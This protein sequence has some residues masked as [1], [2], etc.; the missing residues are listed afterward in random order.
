[1]KNCWLLLYFPCLFALVGKT[2]E[3]EVSCCPAGG[4]CGAVSQVAGRALTYC[5]HYWRL[6]MDFHKFSGRATLAEA[7]RG[8]EVFKKITVYPTNREIPCPSAAKSN[9]L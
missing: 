9:L 6:D 4:E 7:E 1:M 2:L 8:N 3:E 5:M